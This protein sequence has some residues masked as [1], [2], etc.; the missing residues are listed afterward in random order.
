MPPAAA[1]DA[2]QAGRVE[3]L[4]GFL[5]VV[6]RQDIGACEGVWRGLQSRLAAPGRLSHLEKGVWQLAR[7]VAEKLA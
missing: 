3:W 5:D 4:R 1:G 2:D 6:H 7:Y